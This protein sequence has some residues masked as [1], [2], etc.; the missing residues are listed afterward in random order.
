MKTIK[1]LTFLILVSLQAGA[2]GYAH[3]MFVA[4]KKLQAGKESVQPSEKFVAKKAKPSKLV[5]YRAATVKPVAAAYSTDLTKEFE[6]VTLNEKILEAG[7]SLFTSEEA[8][9]AGD[10]IVTKL[11]AFVKSTIYAFLGLPN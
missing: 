2:T 4:H 3:N 5:K 9:S 1:L 10:S 8:S 7:P 6:K 11:I